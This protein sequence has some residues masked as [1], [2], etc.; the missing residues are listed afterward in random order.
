MLHLRNRRFPIICG[1]V[2]V[3]FGLVDAGPGLVV[4]VYNRSPI[5]KCEEQIAVQHTP[6]DSHCWRRGPLPAT[7]P[8]ALSIRTH[9]TSF[10]AVPVK[11]RS[12][13]A[14]GTSN[15]SPIEIKIKNRGWYFDKLTFITWPN[16][17]QICF[18]TCFSL[19]QVGAVT[20]VQARPSSVTGQARV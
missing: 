16:S 7:R 9:A 3:G 2:D 18:S 10:V 1:L 19:E 4:V 20:S 14:D 8:A 12:K 5:N 17:K 15:R 6:Q 13:T 11:Q